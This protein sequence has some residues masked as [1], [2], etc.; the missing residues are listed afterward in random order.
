MKSFWKTYQIGLVP[1]PTQVPQAVLE[2]YTTNF[3]STDLEKDFFDYY[4]HMQGRVQKLLH[5]QSTVVFM[6]GE[7]MVTLWG[8]LKSLILPGDKV[9][10][11][12]TGTSSISA[13]AISLSHIGSD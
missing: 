5:T 7:A 6:T 10:S 9:L 8:A 3:G 11:I 12:G 4:A 1:G 2:A 13:F